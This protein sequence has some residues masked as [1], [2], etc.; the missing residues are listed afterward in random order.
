MPWTC[1]ASPSCYN[2]NILK[3]F[4]LLGLLVCLSALSASA[5]L[6]YYVDESGRRIYV[7]AE[8]KPVVSATP[9]PATKPK[10]IP[11]AIAKKV[12][13]TVPAIPFAPPAPVAYSAD[14]RIDTL[15]EETARRHEVDASLVKAV[16]KAESNNN[17]FAVSHKGA[18]GL[19]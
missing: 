8:P 7:N 5:Q 15:V 17:P 6:A 1:L 10:P 14:T 11:A 3:H 13:L 4:V 12:K 2:C 18:Q 9:T 19:M 16:M